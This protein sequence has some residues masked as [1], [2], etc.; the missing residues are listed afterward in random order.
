[1]SNLDVETTAVGGTESWTMPPIAEIVPPAG[2]TSP[3]SS[4][5]TARVVLFPSADAV[6]VASPA[7][8]ALTTPLSTVATAGV[9][10]LQLIGRDSGSP[11]TSRATAERVAVSP[12]TRSRAVSETVI[13]S[14]GAGP[15]TSLQLPEITRA[16]DATT[17]QSRFPAF[18]PW[19][20]CGKLSS[21]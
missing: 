13:L 12:G 21:Q 15:A 2:P 10:E 1:M 19:R 9:D 17:P 5:V 6:M 11:A 16:A 3:P 20:I 14:T 7:A 4:T 18:I 8:T